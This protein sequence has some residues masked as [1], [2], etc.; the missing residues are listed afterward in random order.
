MFSLE[1]K[2]EPNK[3]KAS[4]QAIVPH[5][6]GDHEV[7]EDLQKEYRQFLKDPENFQHKYLEKGEDLLGDGLRSYIEEKIS[8]F[9][10]DEFVRK[11]APCGSTQ[12]NENLNMIVGTKNPKIRFYG[13]SSDFCTAASVAQANERC[14]YLTLVCDRLKHTTYIPQ[15]DKFLTIK[16]R[17]FSKA[18]LRRAAVKYKRRRKSLKEIRKRTTKI[19]ESVEGT[20]YESGVGADQTAKQIM[21]IIDHPSPH[22]YKSIEWMKES[23]HG[24]EMIRYHRPIANTKIEIF[25]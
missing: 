16:N 10:T 23:V 5:A 24:I 22:V 3:L 21:E 17:Q 12:V 1:D 18:K 25:D 20:T 19:K 2:D 9:T 4:F 6:F 7:C 14:S 8:N 15:L 11:L 13:G